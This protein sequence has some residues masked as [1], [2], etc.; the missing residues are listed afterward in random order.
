M[1]LMANRVITI[2]DAGFRTK[3]AAVSKAVQNRVRVKAAND[4]ATQTRNNAARQIGTVLNLRAANIKKRLSVGRASKQQLVFIS[5]VRGEY[6]MLGAQNFI[7]WRYAGR[8][9]GRNIIST[10]KVTRFAKARGKRGLY[11]RF[12]KDE[13]PM[14]FSIA[15]PLKGG[16][17]FQRVEP[18]TRKSA[19]AWSLNMPIER[20]VGP[21]VWGE[22]GAELDEHVRFGRA[23]YRKRLE[24]WIDHEIR[25]RYGR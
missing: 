7:G 15:F 1:D 11:V 12:Y 2:D 6:E 13:P 17:F 9:R 5:E 25:R 4:A 20:I 8:Q 19:K 3:M 21:S 10:A 18:S 24:Y 14:H 16:N 23:A 22:F